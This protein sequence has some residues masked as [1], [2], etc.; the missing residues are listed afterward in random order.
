MSERLRHTP[1]VRESTA[2]T[3]RKS[4]VEVRK[5]IAVGTVYTKGSALETNIAVATSTPSTCVNCVGSTG[6]PLFGVWKKCLIEASQSRLSI[7]NDAN[8][9]TQSGAHA[10]VSSRRTQQCLVAAERRKHPPTNLVFRNWT[11]QLAEGR[12]SYSHRA[13]LIARLMVVYGHRA[14]LSRM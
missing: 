3:G 6:P 4:G 2:S 10:I 8:V 14:G 11:S 12:L 7:R 5:M 9:E 13:I 1:L